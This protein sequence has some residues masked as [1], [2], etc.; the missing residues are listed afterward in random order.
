MPVAIDTF[1]PGVAAAAIAAGAAILN[2]PTGLREPEMAAVAAD[3]GVGVVLTH[4]F[5]PPKVRPTSL[6]RRRRP[7]GGLRVGAR[8]ARGGRRGGH[9]G[10][11]HRHRPRRRARQVARPGPRAAAPH[12]RGRRAGPA[13]A[14]PDLQQEGAR[15]DHRPCR[16]ERRLAGTAAGMVWCRARG[17]TVFRVHD[18]AV[19]AGRAASSPTPS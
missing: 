16:A 17:A 9:P 3:G 8:A 12:R 1:K 18:V 4:F 2:D 6:P 5:G 11:A 13:G 10:R 7:G 15:G 14:G 19:P